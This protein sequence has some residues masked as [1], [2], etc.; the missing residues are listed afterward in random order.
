MKWFYNLRTA[1]KLVSS[2]I[3]V[4][5][6][7]GIVGY[8]GITSLKKLNKNTENIYTDG[9]GSIMTLTKVQ[10]NLLNARAETLAIAYNDDVS[11]IAKSIE[12]INKLSEDNN[13][14][15]KEYNSSSLNDEEKKLMQEFLDNLNTY[16]PFRE[17]IIKLVQE[18][19]RAEAILAIKDT[20]SARIGVQESVAKLIELNKKIAEELKNQSD[21]QTAKT[22]RTM[23]LFTFAGLVL[24]IIFGIIISRVITGPL[25][26]GVE[27]AEAFGNGDLTRSI[28]LDSR[29]EI[30][31]LA[32]ALNR[33]AENTR[34]LIKEVVANAGE[35]SASSEELSATVEEIAAQTENIN[36]G[37]QEIAAGMEETSAATE[38]IN[39][40]GTEVANATV[41]LAHKAEA[42]NRA[43]QEI[44]NRAEEM[45]TGAEKSREVAKTI[46]EDKQARILKAI[47]DGKVVVEIGK[48]AEI[49]SAIA[50]QTN[51]LALNAA[52]EAARA[53]E[54][55]RGFAVVADEVRKLAEQSATTVSGIQTVISKVQDAFQ[56]LSGTAG[57]IL[58]FIDEKV[59]ADYD[60]LVQTGYQY[61]KDADFVGQ[62]VED[63]AASTQQITASIEQVNKAID[64]VAATAQQAATGAQGIAPHVAETSRAVEEVAKVSQGQAELAQQLNMMVNKFK[65]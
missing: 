9:L 5:L 51:L 31:I 4:A 21:V 53:G 10:E 64:S 40:S 45:R 56:N 8:V 48:M 16:R 60:S 25:K 46:Y 26:K 36:A 33:A 3:V 12:T 29:D 42:G 1:T 63:F 14:L 65:V 23:I 38:E 54:Q 22:N 27:F 50:D 57:D 15:I 28:D 18:N 41:Q 59:T 62:L 20:A 7:I 49:I 43:A 6:F 32:Q 30:G 61:K 2:F 52:I 39:A 37:T 24:A 35:M 34:R 11:Q 17:K 47:E 55:G 58:K 13:S 44:E 19:K